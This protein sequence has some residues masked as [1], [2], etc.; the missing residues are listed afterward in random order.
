MNDILCG[1]VY[2]FQ[3]YFSNLFY[4]Q[5]MCELNLSYLY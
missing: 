5:V 4:I 1:L 3:L 2:Q